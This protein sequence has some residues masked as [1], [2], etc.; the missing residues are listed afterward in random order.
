MDG[1]YGQFPIGIFPTNLGLK[2]L[3]VPNI[4]DILPLFLSESEIYSYDKLGNIT[5]P[6]VKYYHYADLA[7]TTSTDA[8][9]DAY[10]QNDTLR[11]TEAKMKQEKNTT[12]IDEFMR[13]NI[14]MILGYP[15][16]ITEIENSQKRV[17]AKGMENMIYTA[18]IPQFLAKNQ[19]N[20]A[21][22]NFFGISKNSKNGDAALKF[23]N[24]LMTPE[25]GQIAMQI[26]PTLIPA[27]IEFHASAATVALSENFPK[28]KLDAFLLGSGWNV[29]VFNY[30]SKSTF[31]AI[32]DSNWENFSSQSLLSGL[33]EEIVKTI[34]CEI[35]D[36]PQCQKA[37]P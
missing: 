6:F 9:A 17:G 30:G 18:K 29:K 27:Q 22:Y 34:T 32:I 26:Y 10:A 16:L 2:K 24:F 4:S 19:A 36:S 21:K 1:L 20:L 25:A 37:K 33:G 11:H 7:N 13:G 35:S 28:A 8:T 5:T 12:T 15:S 14:G 23:I 3:F 31:D